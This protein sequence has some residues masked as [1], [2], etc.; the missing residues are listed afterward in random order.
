MDIRVYTELEKIAIFPSTLKE[1][2]LFFNFDGSEIGAKEYFKNP[3][4]IKTKAF[5]EY[6]ANEFPYEDYG[7]FDSDLHR[8]LTTSEQTKTKEQQ[9][10]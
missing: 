3:N 8:Y 6:P 4:I 1:K 7:G 10:A 2:M 5:I 9:N